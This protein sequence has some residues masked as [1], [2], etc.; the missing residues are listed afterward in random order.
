[1]PSC[2]RLTNWM[3][4]N[5]H[6]NGTR[7]GRQSCTES[8]TSTC[9]TS[10]HKHMKGNTSRQNMITEYKTTQHKSEH[11]NL[12]ISGTTITIFSTCKHLLYIQVENHG[13]CMTIMQMGIVACLGWKKSPGESARNSWNE[14][15]E[16]VLSRRGLNKVNGIMVIFTV[17]THSESDTNIQG[18]KRR[19][20]RLWNHL[21]W[22]YEQ[23]VMIVFLLGT[24]L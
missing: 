3:Q 4:W 15:L 14:S 23:K 22:S 8:P 12:N 2:K 19:R 10:K 16:N 13:Y 18:S 24:Y 17:S 7:D 9:T 20:S 11:A 21:I 6:N 5:M 1:M